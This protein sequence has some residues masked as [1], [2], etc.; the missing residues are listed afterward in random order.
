MKIF[1]GRAP[2]SLAFGTSGL[3]GLVTDITDLEA[4]IN[5]RGFLDYPGS[6]EWCELDFTEE[7]DWILLILSGA[8]TRWRGR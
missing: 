1:R 8:G 6:D 7:N 4:Y 2:K 5:T 3:R